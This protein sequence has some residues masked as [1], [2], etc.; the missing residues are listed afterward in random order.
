GRDAEGRLLE[1]FLLEALDPERR[2]WLALARPGR[3]AKRSRI[4][5][6]EEGIEAAVEEVREDGKRAVVFDRPLEH[7]LLERIGHV[8]LPPYIRRP[9]GAPARP[10]ARTASKPIF[11]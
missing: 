7:A 2:R 3:R 9:A 6:F 11:S 1:I 8:T 5:R 4:I 10:V